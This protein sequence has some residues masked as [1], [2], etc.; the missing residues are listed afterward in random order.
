MPFGEMGQSVRMMLKQSNRQTER[1]LTPLEA[2]GHYMIRRSAS[3]FW[4][5]LRMG[6][7]GNYFCRILCAFFSRAQPLVSAPSASTENKKERDLGTYFKVEE[8][9]N[10]PYPHLTLERRAV[11]CLVSFTYILRYQPASILVKLEIPA[12]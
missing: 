6:S 10:Y 2:A 1:L 8:F 5:A 11:F 12:G 7:L 4:M 9:G 3:P